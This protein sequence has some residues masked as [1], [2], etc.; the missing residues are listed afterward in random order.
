MENQTNSRTLPDYHIHTVLCKHAQ[1]NV[2]DYKEAA[3]KLEIAEICFADH[4]PN[5]DGYSPLTRME[6]TQFP[7]YRDRVRTQQDGE[8]PAVLFGIEADYYDGC[9]VF[10]S[11]WLPAQGFDFVLGSVHSVDGLGFNDPECR[12]IWDSADMTAVCKKYFKTVRML[13]DS[14]LFDAVAHFDLPKMFGRRPSDTA[15]KEI[16]KPVLDRIS[17][18]GMGI[19]LNTRGL[20]KP[21]GEIYP[22]PFILSLAREREI[23]I[24]FG[25]DSHSPDEVGVGFDRALKMAHEA[26]YKSYFKISQRTKA[27][28]P[29]P[30]AL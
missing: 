6:M 10:L 3:Q 23:P 7:T 30:E 17:G 25:S 1:G 26:G 16:V 19:E 27:L 21:V 24:C 15:L 28:T 2:E 8:A 12:H 13:A 20:R 18:A 14:G 9:E 29:L 4:A 22:S 11:K 5:P